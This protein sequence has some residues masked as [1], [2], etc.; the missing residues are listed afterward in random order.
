[1]RIIVLLSCYKN[2][3]GYIKCHQGKSGGT[4]YY[5]NMRQEMMILGR[6]GGGDDKDDSCYD[7]MIF[8]PGD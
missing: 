1:M 7:V 3:K 2:L 8:R 6:G 5:E 4:D